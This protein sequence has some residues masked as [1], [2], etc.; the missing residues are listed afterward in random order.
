MASMLDP[1]L[2]LA[3]VVKQ[4]KSTQYVGMAELKAIEA[5]ELL[6][7]T[8]TLANVG[9]RAVLSAEDLKDF[10]L[11]NLVP[12]TKT[13]LERKLRLGKGTLKYRLSASREWNA[14]QLELPYSVDEKAERWFIRALNR[15][16]NENV[17]L[18]V[19]TIDESVG[20]PAG[21]LAIAQ[22]LAELRKD[23]VQTVAFVRGKALG[24]VGVLALACDHL[25]MSPDGVLGGF[26]SDASGL[27]K[28]ELDQLRPSIKQLATT[29]EKDWSIMMA[30]LDPGLVVTQYKDT[31]ASGHIRL[32]TEDEALG[33]GDEL[34][35]WE[36]Q[37]VLSV[38]SGLNSKTAERFEL[39]RYIAEDMEQLQAFYQLSE[40]PQPVSYTHLTLPTILLV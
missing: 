25:I 1:A 29:A 14:I 22:Q 11:I 21:C 7:E 33:L 28:S 15:S 16:R 30:M 6:E 27:E 32:M 38:S 8:K 9:E 19:V 2:G 34:E 18:V 13:D 39:T 35:R 20:E 31:K 24:P 12:E 10:G 40:L 23:D 17:N 3:R 37:D 5:K 36:P 26:D 4:D